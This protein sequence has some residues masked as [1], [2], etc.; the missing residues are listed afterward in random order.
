MSIVSAIVSLGLVYNVEAGGNKP[1]TRAAADDPAPAT[2]SSLAPANP[3]QG[4]TDAGKISTS[5]ALNQV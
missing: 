2:G 1:E 3:R 4:W 5:S